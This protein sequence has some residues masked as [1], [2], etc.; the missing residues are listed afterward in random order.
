[1]DA[2]RKGVRAEREL[3]NRLWNLG[4]AVI[5]GPASGSGVRKRFV[6]D[7]VAIR[8]GRVIIL[9]LKYRSREEP[10]QIKIDRILKLKEFSERAG[11]SAYIAVKYGRQEWRLIPIEKLLTNIDNTGTKHVVVRPEYVKDFP[12]LRQVVQNTVSRSIEDM[13]RGC[14]I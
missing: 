4:F 7:L 6:P 9:E 12:T 14:E 5:R 13:L 11:G 3:A 10:I 8:R 2:K 1:M